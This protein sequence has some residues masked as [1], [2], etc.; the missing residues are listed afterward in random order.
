MVITDFKGN[1]KKEKRHCN[2]YVVLFKSRVI[3]YC[4]DEKDADSFIEFLLEKATH[5][6]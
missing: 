3:G 4:K 5:N 2:T 1:L 6:E